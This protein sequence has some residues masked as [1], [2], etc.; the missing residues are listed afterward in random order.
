MRIHLAPISSL[1]CV[2]VFHHVSFSCDVPPQ[3]PSV[4]WHARTI[5]EVR[6]EILYRHS[7]CQCSRSQQVVHAHAQQCLITIHGVGSLL[8]VLAVNC[9]FVLQ[10]EEDITDLRRRV[11]GNLFFLVVILGI[12]DVE[13]QALFR[14][15]GG[16]VIYSVYSLQSVAPIRQLVLQVSEATVCS[17]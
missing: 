14:T 1:V 17:N 15:V 10:G 3:S 16:G 2:Y 12:V 5:A 4:G 9:A 7:H 13:G 11:T 8:R 6:R